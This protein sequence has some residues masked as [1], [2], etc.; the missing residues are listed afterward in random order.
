MHFSNEHYNYL[1][2]L[3]YKL[4]KNMSLYLSILMCFDE[5]NCICKFSWVHLENCRF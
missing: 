5:R 1:E 3:Y 4:F 2:L